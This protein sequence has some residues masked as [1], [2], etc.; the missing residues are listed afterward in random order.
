MLFTLLTE[1]DSS[2]CDFFDL[3]RGGRGRVDVD[4]GGVSL[5]VEEWDEEEEGEGG[6][7]GGGYL[8]FTLHHQ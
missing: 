4:G 1:P 3:V 6:R 7:E 8:V 2:G 5:L